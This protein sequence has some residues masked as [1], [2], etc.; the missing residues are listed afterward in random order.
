MG[1]VFARED[2][3]Q[4][5]LKISILLV[6]LCKSQSPWGGRWRDTEFDFGE[7]E[8]RIKKNKEILSGSTEKVGNVAL[9][10]RPGK[11]HLSLN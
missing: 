4:L 6:P 8:S 10:L 2:P 1:Y 7:G 5:L 9:F 3:V 11:V